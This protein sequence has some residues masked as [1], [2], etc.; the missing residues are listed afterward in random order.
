MS[1]REEYHGFVP[2]FDWA[3]HV[4]SHGYGDK[5]QISVSVDIWLSDRIG[6]DDVKVPP[7]LRVKA[8]SRIEQF[9][10]IHETSR[11]GSREAMLEQRIR[12]LQEV[13]SREKRRQRSAAASQPAQMQR[14][15]AGFPTTSPTP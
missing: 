9:T 5:M 13:L 14:H 1:I 3:L 11:L 2:E 8:V 12:T 4:D 15:S 10:D 6:L 7:R